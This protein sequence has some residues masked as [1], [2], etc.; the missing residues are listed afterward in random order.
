MA[1]YIR[2]DECIRIIDD[3]INIAKSQ[4]TENPASYALKFAK[5]FIK[6]IDPANVQ[7]LKCGGWIRVESSD[8]QTNKAYKCSRCKRLQYYIPC[9]RPQYCPHCGA[10][11]EDGENSYDRSGNAVPPPFAEALVRANLP[12]MCG[13]KYES[14]KEL[15]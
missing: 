13:K 15:Q 5:I 12:E 6:S 11:M 3:L 2:K 1:E 9:D 14:I 4:Q 8:T 7:E 10:K